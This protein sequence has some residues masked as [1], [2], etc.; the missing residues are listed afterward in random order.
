MRV[1]HIEQA[2]RGVY[3]L[4]PQDRVRLEIV[5]W[6]I[7]RPRHL[8]WNGHHDE[9]H[10]ELLVMRHVASE[11]AYLNGAKFRPAIVRL[12]WNCHDLRRYLATN[13]DSLIDYGKRYRSK[14]P[15]STSRAEFCVDEIANARMAK[16]QRMRSCAAGSSSCR[17][18]P[19]CRVG[20]SPRSTKRSLFGSLTDQNFSTPL[21]RS[22]MPGW[23]T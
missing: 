16:K 2:V 5:E 13:T 19:R 20:R 15:L 10:R 17:C 12:P 6:R 14:L 4:D 7:G 1:Q 21:L 8:I 23:Q 3:A 22:H 9:A 18:R 11:I